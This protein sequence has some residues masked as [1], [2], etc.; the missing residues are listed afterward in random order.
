M[1]LIT[2]RLKASLIF[3]LILGI[4]VF[5]LTGCGTD[6]NKSNGEAEKYIKLH[7]Q[8]LQINNKALA[9]LT[10]DD[11]ADFDIENAISAVAKANEEVT[12]LAND[13]EKTA[14][15]EGYGERNK[16]IVG[17]LKEESILFSKT[18]VAL[19]NPNHSTV[20]DLGSSII[21]INQKVS[22]I[23]FDKVDYND[24][25]AIADVQKKLDAFANYY[26]APKPPLAKEDCVLAGISLN[27]TADELE[28]KIGK[29]KSVEE[30]PV[31]YYLMGGKITKQLHHTYEGVALLYT[32][33][34]SATD[35]TKS[36]TTDKTPL[37]ISLTDGKYATSRNIRVG[38]I[39]NKIFL[40]YSKTQGH[41][42]MRSSDNKALISYSWQVPKSAYHLSIIVD[43]A[44]NRILEILTSGI[45]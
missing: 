42:Y 31:S 7:E 32:E 35:K 38:D 3:M 18:Q 22:H 34:Y 11:F 23:K 13:L 41:E 39:V 24:I 12:K 10:C 27:V 43:P 33:H 28:G 44:T 9:S 8:I 40:R 30:I 16:Y 15:P 37:I 4:A 6:S 21:N 45:N 19:I 25:I 36:T 1:N 26:N 5:L 14:P 17:L 20:A 29:L 2:G